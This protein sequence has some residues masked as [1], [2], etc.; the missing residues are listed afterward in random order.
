MQFRGLNQIDCSSVGTLDGVPISNSSYLQ[1]NGQWLDPEIVP[2][3]AMLS[4]SP[5]ERPAE[6]QR[7]VEELNVVPWTFSL[8]LPRRGRLVHE[9]PLL[10][11]AAATDGQVVAVYKIVSSD[12]GK[13]WGEA[14][15]TGEAEHF[16]LGKKL[17]DQ[18]YA[19]R[20]IAG[21]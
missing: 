1:P 9:Q 20:L 10:S 4:M 6:V 16:L 21:K 2:H 3:G 8:V 11:A 19:A 15:I 7:M 17:P 14:R 12:N 18:P 5:K 13:T